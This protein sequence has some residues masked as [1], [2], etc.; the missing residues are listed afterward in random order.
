MADSAA[1]RARRS[2]AHRAG[3][4][5]LCRPERCPAAPAPAGGQETTAGEIDAALTRYLTGLELPDDDPRS[6]LAAVASKL[7]RALDAHATASV[8]R[9]LRGCVTELIDLEPDEG[10]QATAARLLRDLKELTK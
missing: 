8:A 10:G 2:R 7:A 6:L 3:D 4:H 1:L 9:E 5:S